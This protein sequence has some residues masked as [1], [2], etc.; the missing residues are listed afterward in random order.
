MNLNVENIFDDMLDKYKSKLLNKIQKV[1]KGGA[2]FEEV[3]YS[4]W[5]H[6]N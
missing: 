6:F 5:V 2:A 4:D 1:Y 3:Y